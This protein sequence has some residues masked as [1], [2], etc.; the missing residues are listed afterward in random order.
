PEKVKTFSDERLTFTEEQVKAE[1]SRCLS[2]GQAKVDQ[3]ICIGCGLCTVQCNFDA[4]HLSKLPDEQCAEGVVYE[5]IIPKV[6]KEEV[7]KTKRLLNTK[8]HAY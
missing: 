6:V 5:K 2:C 8:I 3:K 4:I 1:T 7:K